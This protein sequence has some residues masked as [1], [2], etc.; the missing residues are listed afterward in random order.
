MRLCPQPTLQPR[1]SCHRSRPRRDPDRL[2]LL[3][4]VD[5]GSDLTWTMLHDGPKGRSRV[6]PAPTGQRRAHAEDHDR[7]E[8][9]EDHAGYGSHDVA[10]PRGVGCGRNRRTSFQALQAVLVRGERRAHRLDLG[11][12]RIVVSG[13]EPGHLE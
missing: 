4:D 10:N 12:H 3:I 13:L 9:D 6:G 2:G 8:Q 7:H 1:R 11:A 5:R